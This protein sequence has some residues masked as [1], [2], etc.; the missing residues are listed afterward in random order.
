MA[1]WTTCKC[2][3]VVF[4]CDRTCQ[5]AQPVDIVMKK[6]AIVGF[7]GQEILSKK[8]QEAVAEVDFDAARNLLHEWSGFM[9]T[10]NAI[11]AIPGAEPCSE[12]VRKTRCLAANT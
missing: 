12:M 7:V 2:G 9:E 10:F 4:L 6:A 1:I 11:R 5:F 8:L 3:F